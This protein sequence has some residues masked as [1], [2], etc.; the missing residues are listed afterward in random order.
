MVSFTKY[1]SGTVECCRVFFSLVWREIYYVEFLFQNRTNFMV[2]L[3]N[4]N[5]RLRTYE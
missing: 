2:I 3:A 1:D 5:A 4:G